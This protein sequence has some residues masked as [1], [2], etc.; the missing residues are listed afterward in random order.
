MRVF[1]AD[2]NRITP[3][4]AYDLVFLIGVLEWSRGF[5]EGNN[6][7]ER[8]IQIAS[9][10]LKEN[11]RLVLAI[12][13]QIGLKYFL[14]SGEDHCGIPME[15]LQG[16]PRFDRAETF[17]RL[18]L[19]RILNRARLSAVQVMYPFPDYKLARVVLTDRAVELCSESIAYWASRHKFEDYH[20][21]DRYSHGN[22]T[23][24]ATEIT[25]AGLLGELGNSFLVVA[26]RQ[27]SVLADPPWLVWS[28][29]VT[30][31]TALSSITT[32][33]NVDGKLLVRK[34]FPRHELLESRCG[35][36]FSTCD[37]YSRNR[38]WMA[39]ALR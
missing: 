20:V 12:E 13:N 18:K 4:P 27:E 30:K 34:V 6:P 26:A 24:V 7:V 25:K 19:M 21:P 29:R 31:N 35:R 37:R 17:S 28:E 14:G 1:A 15:S 32:L 5:I 36:L 8:C 39:A 16:Y 22:Q 23:L 33:E 2:I 9:A 3:E 38:S 11:G 10:M